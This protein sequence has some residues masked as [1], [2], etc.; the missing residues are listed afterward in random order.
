MSPSARRR[1]RPD[2]P[3]A[4]ARLRG[5]P[6][7]RQQVASRA[8]RDALFL[9]AFRGHA[10]CRSRWAPPRSPRSPAPSCSPWRSPA[11]RPHA[12][13]R[14][15]AAVSA[16]LL[17]VWCAVASS[18]PRAAALARLHPRRRLR[19]RARLRL[20]VARQRALRPVHRAP[21]RRPHRHRRHRRRRRRR[22][23]RAGSRPDAAARRERAAAGRA[24]PARGRALSPHVGERAAARAAAGLAD[25][26]R[27][28][29]RRRSCCAP[30]TCATIALLR[31]PR[32]RDRGARRLPVQ[33][34]RP[35]ARFEGGGA[36]LS[37][38]APSTPG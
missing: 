38:L 5:V 3:P 2:R 34:R 11:A 1:A 13:C 15:A 22:R 6:A 16:L 31:A 12:S 19:R 20:L 30:R 8:V 23:A 10:R 36:L 9:S 28:D 21:L 37:V 33:G 18:F 35:Q 32:R 4:A 14:R 17:G 26:P 25:R 27:V 24:R 29:R 7:D